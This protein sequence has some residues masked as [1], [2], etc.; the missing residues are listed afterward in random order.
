MV[1]KSGVPAPRV[2]LRVRLREAGAPLSVAPF[3]L[4]FAARVVSWA[5]SAVSPLAMAFAVLHLPG[6]GPSALG[7]VLAAGMVPQIVLLLAGGVVA[8]RASRAAVMLW[9]NVVS[10]VASGA[11]ALLLWQGTARVWHL[12]VV[13]A[14]C[15]AAAAFFQPAAGG[16]IKDVVPA[17]LR[18]QANALL[19]LAQNAVKVGGPALGGL[20][21]ATAGP[22][23]AIA[24]DGL[25]FV[26]AALLCSRL[27]LAPAPVKVRAGFVRDLRQGWVDF[28]SRP[29]LWTM[30]VQGAVVV[31]AWL[32]GYQMLGPTYADR[33]LHGA[34]AWGLVVAGFTGGLLAGAGV[35][36]LWRPVRVGVVV[37]VGTG[38]MA[39]PL[40][41]M[42]ARVP[43]P[44][45]VATT[46][47]AGA[48]LAVSATSWATAVQ[49]RIAA[50]R[51]G[52]ITSYSTLG[53]TL[54]VPVGYLVAGPLA[55]AVGLRNT[56]AAGAAL[57]VAAMLAPLC[58]AQVR[59]LTLAPRAAEET[60]TPVAAR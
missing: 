43:V 14:M 37:C 26:A 41:G 28:A 18:H 33:Y 2:G 50:D 57:I 10:A 48:G 20:L 55:Q 22:A 11:A 52:R 25:T 7:W 34:A 21:V 60:V 45:L 42:A 3:R 35:A 39:L 40:A 16:V 29:W 12:V 47:V 24:W 46:L 54:P 30:V 8:D 5:G 44:V 1:G 58:L 9:S 27:R 56:L 19:R 17:E 51:L 38:T 31:P 6:G 53:Q 4:H 15:G 36:L 59:A 32:V 23:W 49:E 13:S